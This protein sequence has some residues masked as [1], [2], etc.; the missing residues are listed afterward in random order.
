MIDKYTIL[1][2]QFIIFYDL[3]CSWVS[4]HAYWPF[5][6]MISFAS[7]LWPSRN[8]WRWPQSAFCLSLPPSVQLSLRV[9]LDSV[10][11]RIRCTNC[12][13]LCF[14]SEYDWPWQGLSFQVCCLPTPPPKQYVKEWGEFS[15]NV[16]P[17]SKF[18]SLG[19]QAL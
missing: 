18:R 14:S 6:E 13:H 12:L 3:Q 10:N 5:V 8:M 15:A 11:T 16:L 19:R 2:F 7:Q 9:A 1:L 4:F 17:K